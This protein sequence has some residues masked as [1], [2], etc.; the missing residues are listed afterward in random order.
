MCTKDYGLNRNGNFCKVTPI[1]KIISE[2]KVD[3][4]AVT[5]KEFTGFSS[6]CNCKFVV[7]WVLCCGTIC[8]WVLFRQHRCIFL[9]ACLDH[10]N[11]YKLKWT[12]YGV[13]SQDCGRSSMLVFHSWKSD[14]A[15]GFFRFKS[16]LS[17]PQPIVKASI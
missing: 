1:S 7:F 12:C 6:V 14:A 17:A 10:W 11:I 9:L 13:H 3:A 2:A 4:R 8:I 16:S 15:F 5:L